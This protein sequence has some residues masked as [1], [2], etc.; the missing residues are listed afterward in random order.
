[1][2]KI[3]LNKIQS[4]IRLSMSKKAGHL[5][6]YLS[7]SKRLRRNLMKR[8]RSCSHK[9]KSLRMCAN[10]MRL[11]LIYIKERKK[12]GESELLFFKIIFFCHILGHR[13]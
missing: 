2:S 8:S 5:N 1:M 4:K 12:E 6:R 10:A 9:S 13:K 11:V 7:M 3:R